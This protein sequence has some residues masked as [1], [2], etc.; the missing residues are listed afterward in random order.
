VLLSAVPPP[1]LLLRPR[2]EGM[3]LS[4]LGASFAQGSDA[5]RGLVAAAAGR[6]GLG[7][8]A[9]QERLAH[10]CSALLDAVVARA[11]V[12]EGEA[13]LRGEDAADHEA[14]CAR[15]TLDV[16]GIDPAV[17]ASPLAR[18][19]H[20]LYL[21]APRVHRKAWRRP[22][23]VSPADHE[24][25]AS[26][27][28]SAEDGRPML[29]KHPEPFVA[30]AA[31]SAGWLV[32]PECHRLNQLCLRPLQRVYSCGIPTD[33]SLAALA[34]LGTPLAELGCGTGYWAR[35]LRA[36]GVDVV[37]YDIRPPPRPGGG[38]EEEDDEE[39]IFAQA[40]VRDRCSWRPPLSPSSSCRP[41]PPPPPLLPSPPP[42]CPGATKL[43]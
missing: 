30:R 36:R 8:L 35:L 23:D 3:R 32:S 2:E 39:C 17:E 24:V 25:L 28:A 43:Q 14:T 4:P 9:E 40:R 5:V 22:A 19:V 37:A 7:E 12:L 42:S 18:A 38:D 20:E 11:E 1:D 41:L 27:H 13:A 15:A 31:G 29:A 10:G 6:A 16:L 33:A 21:R 34:A 26:L